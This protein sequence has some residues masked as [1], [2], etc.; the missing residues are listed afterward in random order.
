[1]DNNFMNEYPYTDF[2]EL[3][4]DYLLQRLKAV[5]AQLNTIKEDIESEVLAWVQEQL[6]PYEQQLTEL[7]AEVQNLEQTTQETLAQYDTRI[8]NFINEINGEIVE[9]R[10]ELVNSI[11]AVN[12]LTD[13]KIEQNNIYLLNEIT[14]NVGD[15]FVVLNPFT[16]ETVTIQDMVDYLSAFH[17]NDAIDYD[18][19]ATRALTY[20]QFEALNITY[21]DLTLHGNTLY[22]QEDK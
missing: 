9:I 4:A 3:N 15:L 5:E 12:A 16:G 11:N 1:M 17:I 21:T 8:T 6:V 7:I 10:T 18:T 13:L 20:T 22:V 2:H 14:E 19:M